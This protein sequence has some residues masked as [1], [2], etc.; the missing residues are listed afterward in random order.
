MRQT[1][2]EDPRMPAIP[3]YAHRR[4]SKELTP[5]RRTALRSRMSYTGSSPK[6]KNRIRQWMR[7]IGT[8][9]DFAFYI[10]FGKKLRV[11]IHHSVAGDAKFLCERA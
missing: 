8:G 4:R 5:L 10:T 6:L 2:L 7:D 3:R 1:W 9:S 11:G